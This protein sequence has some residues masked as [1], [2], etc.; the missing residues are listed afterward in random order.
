M[1]NVQWT[2]CIPPLVDMEAEKAYH[3]R[4]ENKR[5]GRGPVPFRE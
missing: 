3:K 4:D 2:M 1:D 5:A